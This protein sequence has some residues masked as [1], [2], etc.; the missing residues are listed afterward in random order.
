MLA[1]LTTDRDNKHLMLNSTI[2][3]AHQ[4][5]ASGKEA[6]DQALG[7]SR[8]GLTTKVHILADAL[9]RP[10]RLIITVSEVG[11]IAQALALLDG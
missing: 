2:V 9:G 7:H 8:G 6:A 5:A 4:Q 3:H 11:N 10:L 1:A